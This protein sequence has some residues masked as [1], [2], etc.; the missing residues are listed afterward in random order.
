MKPVPM[1]MP[2]SVRRKGVLAADLV[3]HP[4]KQERAQ[5]ADQEARGEQC[6]RA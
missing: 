4:S 1:P 2:L 3:A 5:R 6:N